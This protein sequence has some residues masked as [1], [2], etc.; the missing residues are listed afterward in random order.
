[1]T[2]REAFAVWI[3][4]RLMLPAVPRAFLGSGSFV[5]LRLPVGTSDCRRMTARLPGAGTHRR[6]SQGDV[7]HVHSPYS[8]MR[9]GPRRRT[10]GAPNPPVIGRYIGY[11]DPTRM[12]R[13]LQSTATGSWDC[14]ISWRLATSTKCHGLPL[15]VKIKDTRSL[16][17][18]SGMRLDWQREC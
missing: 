9:G 15:R 3:A 18:S 13:R 17:G 12:R 14:G 4:G 5:W 11:D 7:R 6:F 16:E 1:M 10:Q 8:A 2:A